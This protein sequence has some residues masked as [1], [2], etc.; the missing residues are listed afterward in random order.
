LFAGDSLLPGFGGAQFP[1]AAARLCV[2][3]LKITDQTVWKEKLFL[4]FGFEFIYE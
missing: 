2:R 4:W 3:C 1:A